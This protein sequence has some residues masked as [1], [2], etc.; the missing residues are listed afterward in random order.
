MNILLKITAI[1]LTLNF[2]S[3]CVS[4]Q[5]FSKMA[6]QGDTITLAVGSPDGMTKSNTTVQFV[7]DTDASVYDLTI[8]SMLRIRPDNTSYSATFDAPFI[9]NIEKSSSHSA[10]LSILVIDLPN[11]MT[12][13][14][15][16]V[17][18]TTA[19]SYGLGNG[20]NTETIVLEIVAGQ[21]S[22]ASFDYFNG[23]S[24]GTTRS[25]DLSLLEPM[26]QV[27]VRPPLKNDIAF[28]N[29][30]FAAIEL[31]ITVPMKKIGGGVVSL[32][33][34]RVVQDD[35]YV[36]NLSSQTQMFW[37]KNGDDITV[38]FISSTGDMLHF[39]PRFSVVLDVGNEFIATPGPLINS[40]THY[41]INGAVILAEAP[42]ASDYS[43][44]IE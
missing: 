31:K 27:V 40:I 4:S 26:P 7:S 10:W 32:D 1:I 43:I 37:S 20:V 39:Q 21:G 28:P 2:I 17:H 30:K 15:G 24:T 13:G 34:V 42:M 22:P 19:G 29:K 41:D 5:A 6:R 35:L 36:S 38:M 33:D 8:R 16:K 3:G 11:G 23:I 12:V 9:G 18:V 25:G 44:S 14:D